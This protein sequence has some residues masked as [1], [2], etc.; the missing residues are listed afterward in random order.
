MKIVN[1]TSGLGNQIF[2]YIFVEYLKEKHPQHKIYGYYNAKKLQKH[3]GLEVD[4]VFELQLPYHTR[5][6][7]CVAWFSRKLNGVGIKGLKSTDENYCERAIYYDGWWQDKKY[8]LDTFVKIRFRKF[9]LDSINTDLLNKIENSQS[10]F[11][12]IRRGDYLAPEHIAQ[13]GG[14]CTDD[15]YRKGLEMVSNHFN[16]PHF[17]IFSNDIKWVKDNMDIPNSVYVD[18]NEGYNSYIDMFLMS[19]CKGAIL[20]NSSFSYWGAMLNRNNPIV[21]YPQKWFNT[22]TPPDIF[23]KEWISI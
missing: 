7:D 1:F 2:Q 13:Y 11:V 9:E 16:N 20:A 4:K 23:P 12:H 19:N 15:Y 17:F 10:V 14:I 3:N 21:V 6:S 22:R 5:W 18:N 8:F